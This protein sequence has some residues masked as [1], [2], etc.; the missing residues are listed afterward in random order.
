MTSRHLDLDL[1]RAFQVIRSVPARFW[2]TTLVWALAVYAFAVTSGTLQPLWPGRSGTMT[3]LASSLL[4]TLWPL[5]LLATTSAP[6]V[7]RLRPRLATVL[8]AS[9]L[10]VVLTTEPVALM[11]ATFLSF[12]GVAVGATWT[13]PR[14]AWPIGAMSLVVPVALSFG[15]GVLMPGFILDST[16]W[17]PDQ[18]LLVPV[19]YAVGVAAAIG[20]ARVLR[21]GA[22]V[23]AT[24]S[25]LAAGARRLANEES[26]L[27][28]RARIARDLHD[29]VAHRISL[30]AVRAE[31]APYTSPDLGPDARRL[32]AETATDARSALEEMRTVLGVLHRST[33][34]AAR[35][36]QPGAGDIAHLVEEARAAGAEVELVGEV[37]PMSEAT[38]N[39][40]YRVVQE[41]LTNARRHAPASPTTVSLIPEAD[42]LVVTVTNP[43]EAGPVSFGR[44]LTGMRERVELAGGDLSATA[45]DGVFTV[46]VR[47]PGS[48]R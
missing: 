22:L 8:A 35:A 32:L 3:E 34:P 46:V 26:A 38:G 47:L 2:A 48:A 28:E 31:T 13:R 9:G 30:I 39:I 10:L 40:A 18:R 33:D 19:L 15:A 14:L 6:V 16:Y 25:D 21:A 4:P 12:V 23:A 36:P 27:T 29:I 7:A 44:G 1:D 45:R 20:L 41:A 11:F 42:H 17:E 43:A 5:L 37:P 24:R